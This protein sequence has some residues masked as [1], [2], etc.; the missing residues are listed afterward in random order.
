MVEKT[1]NDLFYDTLE[2][3]YFAERQIP[4]KALPKPGKRPLKSEVNFKICL[5]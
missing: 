4:E 3:I 2:G 1:L 5:L